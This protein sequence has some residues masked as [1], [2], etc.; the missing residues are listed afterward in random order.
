MVF[1][2]IYS[3]ALEDGAFTEI[4]ELKLFCNQPLMPNLTELN[5]CFNLCQE[6]DTLIVL[7]QIKVILE[8]TKS[9]MKAVRAM[10]VLEYY[11]RSS[12]VKPEVF[13]SMFCDVLT[14]FHQNCDDTE[15]AMKAKKIILIIS[16][17]NRNKEPET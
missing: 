10:L 6:I 11:L 8:D 17:L 9:N 2:F 14:E 13:N 5:N 4:Q 3:E 7:E 12:K 15:P 16:A 1:S